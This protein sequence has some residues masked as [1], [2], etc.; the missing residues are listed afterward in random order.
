[1][2]N[3]MI[4]GFSEQLFAGTVHVIFFLVACVIT[5]GVAT[6]KIIPGLKKTDVYKS[7]LWHVSE[8]ELWL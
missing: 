4:F 7:Q 6:R 5:S 1:M 8:Y 2:L 3:I